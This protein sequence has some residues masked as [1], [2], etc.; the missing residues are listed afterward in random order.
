MDTDGPYLKC[1][2]RPRPLRSPPASHAGTI[3]KAT[4]LH[5]THKVLATAILS[6]FSQFFGMH[7]SS[8]TDLNCRRRGVRRVLR[9][10]LL[11]L[12]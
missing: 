3:I 12:R 1:L 7:S 2:S 9:A 8:F 5:Q 4:R 10:E 11:C 6:E